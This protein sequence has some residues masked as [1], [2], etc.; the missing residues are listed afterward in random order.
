MAGET[1]LARML[2]TLQPT[3]REGKFVLVS[4]DEPVDLP[5]EATVS[6]DE[7][8]TY[9]VRLEV[10]DRHGW[11]YDFIAGWVTL[12]VHSDLAAVG[13]TAAVTTALAEAGIPANVLAG[14]FH[15]HILVP[16]ERVDDAVATLA[17]LSGRHASDEPAAD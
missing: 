16:I 9:V 6:E 7:G 4:L 13:L 3:V 2:A 15:D 17:L 12:Q 10:A 11:P 5:A 8:I 1:D 14:F